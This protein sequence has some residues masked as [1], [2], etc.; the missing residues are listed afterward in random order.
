[1]RKKAIEVCSVKFWNVRYSNDKT[2]TFNYIDG[3]IASL[4]E[5]LACWG[6]TKKQAILN[7]QQVS[8]NK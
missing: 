5:K 8:G 3:Y 1:M 4:D 6:Q 2:M 7:Y